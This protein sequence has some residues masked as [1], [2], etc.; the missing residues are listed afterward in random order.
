MIPGLRIMFSV[1]DIPTFAAG[2]IV[3]GLIMI[4]IWAL[5][6]RMGVTDR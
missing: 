6:K 1:S 3:I 5:T 2:V 4:G